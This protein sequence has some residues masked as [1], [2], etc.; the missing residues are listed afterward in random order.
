M[1]AL[2]PKTKKRDSERVQEEAQKGVNQLYGQQPGTRACAVHP[3]FW[4]LTVTTTKMYQHTKTYA[5]TKDCGA[6]IS[7]KIS[8][9]DTFGRAGWPAKRRQKIRP[10][11]QVYRA[12]CHTY[13]IPSCFL[14]PPFSLSLSTLIIYRNYRFCLALVVSELSN[15]CIVGTLSQTSSGN[16]SFQ[17]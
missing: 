15:I 7:L 8:K 14:F 2:T 10:R 16:L 9:W 12:G 4:Q 17:G 5:E 11:P 13:E 3:I 6:K 1:C